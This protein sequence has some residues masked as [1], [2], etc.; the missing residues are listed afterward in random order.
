MTQVFAY[1]ADE[2]YV[3]ENTPIDD[4]VDGKLLAI[5]RRQ[6]QEIHIREILGSGIYNVMVSQVNDTGLQAPYADLNTYYIKPCLVNFILYEAIDTI[7]FQ[8][9]N[10][11]LMKRSSDNAQPAS[12]D[13]IQEFAAKWFN[14]AQYYAKRLREHLCENHTTFPLYQNPGTG[15]DTIH[16]DDSLDM[17]LWLGP[18]HEEKRKFFDKP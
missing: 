16:P 6:A 2:Q 12:M 14:K 5:A 4:N 13:D 15:V 11:G 3:K 7:S 10:K 1:F 18:P 17:G 8:V 9:L